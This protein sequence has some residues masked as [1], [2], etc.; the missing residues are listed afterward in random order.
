MMKDKY[1]FT[2]KHNLRQFAYDDY[3]SHGILLPV[4]FDNSKVGVGASLTP[5]HLNLDELYDFSRAV[6]KNGTE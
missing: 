2:I 4:F 1:V 6:S 5:T 3:D